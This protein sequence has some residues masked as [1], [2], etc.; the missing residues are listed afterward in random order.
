MIKNI[1]FDMGNVLLAYTP[2]EYIKTVTSDEKAAE[3]ILK[4]LFYSSEWLK[5]DEGIITE[6]EAVKNVCQ[7]IPQYSELVQKAMDD[8]HTNLTP[9]EGMPE[10][11]KKLKSKNY[12]IYLLSNASLRFYSYKDNFEQLFRHFDG[13]I[14]SAKEKKAKPN[15]DIY[16]CICERFSLIPEECL[17]I[18]DLQRNI[19]GAI[20]AGLNAH[21]FKG[22][23]ELNRYL[24]ELNIL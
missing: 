15:R 16:E 21:L 24:E 3:A 14:I 12:G 11:V 2:H 19:D 8:W 9:I 23:E 20:D 5:L 22:P 18:D 4:E 7:R 17:F 6:E 1:I 10:L 13:I